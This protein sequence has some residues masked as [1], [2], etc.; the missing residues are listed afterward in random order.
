MLEREIKLARVTQSL[1]KTG[2]FVSAIG[3]FPDGLPGIITK[4]FA[5]A[6]GVDPGHWSCFITSRA[7]GDGIQRGQWLL[8][9][10]RY[11]GAGTWVT[12]S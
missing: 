12:H 9:S 6:W 1:S 4:S 8:S 3:C 10:Q 5:L 7:E 11:K 2:L